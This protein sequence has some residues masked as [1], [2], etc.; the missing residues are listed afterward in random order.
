MPQHSH[1]YFETLLN[2]MEEGAMALDRNQTIIAFNRAA[3]VLTGV[4][5][6][7]AIGQ[8][9]YEVCRGSLCLTE[10]CPVL[11]SIDTGQP[12]ENSE[13]T[14]R[15]QDG[16]LRVVKIHTGLLRDKQGNVTGAIEL[17]RDVTDTRA[18]EKQLQERR[19]F[20]NLIG[21]SKP[22]QRL[23]QLIE[24]I[25]DSD[26]TVLILGETG[27]GKE[28][29][30][31]AIHFHSPRA[32]GPLIKVNC[33]A[34]PETLLESELFGHVRGAYTGAVSDKPGRFELADGGTLFLDEIGDISPAVQ[35][36]LLRVLE[37]H[38]FERLGDIR[39]RKVNVRLIT[40]TNK[41][42]R[43]SVAN[44][45]F[46]EDLFYRLNV[47]PIILPTLRERRDDIPLLVEHFIHKLRSRT[48]RG[49][50][51]ISGAALGRLMAHD[52]PGNIRELENTLEFAFV[53]CKNAVI[54]I[55]DLPPIVHSGSSTTGYNEGPFHALDEH[56][57]GERDALLAMLEA[58]RWRMKACAQALG[59]DRTT[60][61]RKMKRYGISRAKEGGQ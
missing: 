39:T 43:A 48:G 8:K 22:M 31:E 17:L 19:Q 14:V 2:A 59:I 18:L 42:L 26:A 9:C 16:D 52:W 51:H 20:T 41:D 11:I 60:L 33:S 1:E 35:L 3:S 36:R 7:Q 45:T 47:V 38:E 25:S 44:R 34:F 27:T 58:T 61:W 6:H 29:V 13:M 28:L 23:Y 37:R 10:T 50:D 40:A 46:R 55:S 15:A 53:A 32:N 12:V 21:K 24:D 5:V 30:A 56:R 57:A 4:P 49:I 54:E